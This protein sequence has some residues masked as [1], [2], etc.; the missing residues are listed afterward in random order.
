MHALPRFGNTN[1]FARLFGTQEQRSEYIYGLLFAG[2][3]I[4][5]WF[6]AWLIVLLVFK[7]LGQ[8]RVG[9]LSG[10][11]MKTVG[12]KRPVMI[13][14]TFIISVIIVVVFS[15]LLVSQGLTQLRT[16]METIY[17][18]SVVRDIV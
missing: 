14:T 1:D 3:F 18:S 17:N 13:R 10:S 12:S 8:R 7:C 16:G 6:I 15:G 2:I 5:A 9:L 11:P 4:Y